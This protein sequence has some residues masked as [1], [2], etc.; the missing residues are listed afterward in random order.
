MPRK[1]PK[2]ETDIKIKMVVGSNET[3]EINETKEVS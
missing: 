1:L 2:R 3:N